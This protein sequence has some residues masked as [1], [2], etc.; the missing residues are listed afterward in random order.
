M[1]TVD[2][3]KGR[4]RV[5]EDGHWLW[6]GS[7]RPCGSPNI[8]A[9]DYTHG[10]RMAVQYGYRAMWHCMT[11]KPIPK[12]HR[13]FSVCEEK[14]CVCP[15]HLVLLTCAEMGARVRKS[16]AM[17]NQTKRIL[18]NRKNAMKLAKMTPEILAYIRNS[19]ETGV[20]LA[21]EL[22]VCDSVISKARRGAYTFMRGNIFSGLI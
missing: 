4:C 17:K 15:D 20:A 3:I 19:D 14:S 10:G 12:G 6:A 13:V 21:K 11:G 9:P 18:A 22:G 2:E 8:Y 1:R 5:T 7:V 16:G